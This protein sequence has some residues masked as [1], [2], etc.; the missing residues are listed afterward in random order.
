MSCNERDIYSAVAGEVTSFSVPNGIKI[1][2][3]IYGED[4]YCNDKPIM[5][6]DPVAYGCVAGIATGK[7]FIRG[8]DPV[9]N[10]RIDDSCDGPF[11]YQFSPDAMGCQIFE[12]YIIVPALRCKKCGSQMMAKVHTKNKCIANYQCP[13]CSDEIASINLE[14]L[15]AWGGTVHDSL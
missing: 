1:L 3:P 9:E 8:F 12:D 2:L 7:Y 11:V 15:A 5:Y 4:D 10:K 14:K 6:T 13:V